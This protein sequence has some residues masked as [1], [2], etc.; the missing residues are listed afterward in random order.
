MN[1]VHH[2]QVKSEHFEMEKGKRQV[3]SDHNC[4]TQSQQVEAQSPTGFTSN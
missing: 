2:V 3:T 4:K 1:D